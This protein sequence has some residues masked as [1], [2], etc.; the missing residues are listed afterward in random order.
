M[1]DKDVQVKSVKSVERKKKQK[2]KRY[3]LSLP[4]TREDYFYLWA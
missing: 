1:D 2:K 3:Y 4:M